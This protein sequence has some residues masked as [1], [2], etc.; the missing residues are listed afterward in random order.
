MISKLTNNSNT[1]LATKM[2]LVPTILLEIVI[3]SLF[4]FKIVFEIIYYKLI[5]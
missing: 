4:L 1:D 2:M 3:I 5:S